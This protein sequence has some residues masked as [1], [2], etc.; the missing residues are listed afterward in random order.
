[1]W[2]TPILNNIPYFPGRTLENNSEVFIIGEPWIKGHYLYTIKLCMYM[3]PLLML[4]MFCSWKDRL[5]APGN[6]EM[7]V[8]IKL[9]G[10]ENTNP[11]HKTRL[12]G[13]NVLFSSVSRAWYFCSRLRRLTRK[14]LKTPCGLFLHHA[15]KFKFTLKR[16]Q[17]IIESMKCLLY[18]NKKTLFFHNEMF[19]GM[20]KDALC[21]VIDF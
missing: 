1:M 17:K 8:L 10:H 3:G 21:S 15:Y 16:C 11:F 20:C 19:L 6:L 5:Q 9:P 18:H 7:R 13:M 12:H 2:I 14:L 4:L